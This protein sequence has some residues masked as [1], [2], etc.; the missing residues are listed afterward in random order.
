[1]FG[2]KDRDGTGATRVVDKRGTTKTYRTTRVTTSQVKVEGTEQKTLMDSNDRGSE[3]GAEEVVI[4]QR[5]MRGE[6]LCE[7]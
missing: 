1:L 7:G 5:V 6:G 4:Q 2:N 3:K